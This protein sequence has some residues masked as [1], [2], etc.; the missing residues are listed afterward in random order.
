M[1]FSAPAATLPH[2]FSP[3]PTLGA[4][5]NPFA[6]R[7]TVCRIDEAKSTLHTHGPRGLGCTCRNAD[8]LCGACQHEGR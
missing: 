2:E 7:C 8:D 4:Y 3:D 5:A 1:S 6:K